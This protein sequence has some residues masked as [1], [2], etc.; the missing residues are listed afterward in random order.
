[1][2]SSRA[3]KQFL[4]GRWIYNLNNKFSECALLRFPTKNEVKDLKAALPAVHNRLEQQIRNIYDD[5]MK[6]SSREQQK[7]WGCRRQLQLR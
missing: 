1:M 3:F 4:A 2:A 7:R 5:K 6:S